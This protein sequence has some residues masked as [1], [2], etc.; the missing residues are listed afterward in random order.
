[1]ATIPQALPTMQNMQG[2]SPG[3]SVVMPQA[4]GVPSAQMQSL[5]GIETPLPSPAVRSPESTILSLDAIPPLEPLKPPNF[6]MKLVGILAAANGNFGP[7]FEIMNME[8]KTKLYQG[9]SAITPQVNR[10]ILSGR[11]EEA[12]NLWNAHITRTSS[13][14]PEIGQLMQPM[15]DRV[16]N[17]MKTA[18][19]VDALIAV[20]KHN[21]D[22]GV[23]ATDPG[24]LQNA[25]S[26]VSV[27]KKL[28]NVPDEK[29]LQQ[30]LQ[31]SV[32]K[33]YHPDP[34]SRSIISTTPMG[35]VQQIPIRSRF[36]P[37]MIKGWV[38][39]T[40][41]GSTGFTVPEIANIANGE[42]VIRG[43]EN[44][45]PS[46]QAAMVQA[47][48]ILQGVDAQRELV[49]QTPVRPEANEADRLA[50]KRQG[51]PDDLIN[52][53]MAT[54]M[55]NIPPQV[56]GLV[57]G[58]T[59]GA[60]PPVEYAE[61]G[62]KVRLDEQSQQAQTALTAQL[63][64]P[65]A[66]APN[67]ANIAIVNKEK[68]GD[69]WT[70]ESREMSYNQAKTS[71]GKWG[72]IDREIYTKKVIPLRDI[73]S[74]LKV[75]PDLF[76]EAGNPE[77]FLERLASGALRSVTFAIGTSDPRQ[78][79]LEAYALLY[80]RALEALAGTAS[81]PSTQMKTM[82]A[83][84]VKGFGSETAA[85]AATKVLADRT[86]AAIDR[87]MNESSKSVTR[88]VEK[89]AKT[90]GLT[91]AGTPI[92]SSVARTTPG[93][94]PQAPPTQPQYSAVIDVISG[95]SNIKDTMSKSTMWPHTMIDPRSGSVSALD[96]AKV[97]ASE[98]VADAKARGLKDVDRFLVRDAD[99]VD[100]VVERLT[101]IE[102]LLTN[103]KA[104]PAQPAPSILPPGVVRHK[105]R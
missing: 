53:I 45:T 85:I 28:R 18:Q 37:D 26:T 39:D 72:P 73:L 22:T 11:H 102:K 81:I 97:L 69:L 38:G 35:N 103:T 54:R 77:G 100:V 34:A 25:A 63:D 90:S 56:Q 17:S 59:Q 7:M 3:Q 29:V 40:L 95:L 87:A 96:I 30:V 19:T 105:G 46:R 67:L 13:V 64:V 32:L 58:Q 93:E 74:D 49:K 50:L 15:T 57:T 88:T 82:K 68:G 27:L 44:V 104:A 4:T 2:T 83:V 84:T 71:G 99:S 79:R 33:S 76:T 61:A 6:G 21:I 5:P 65:I 24:S 91:A 23:Y 51:L 42:A 43:S 94:T 92:P 36:T 12:I 62:R 98:R 10:M 20:G 47:I 101:G 52:L 31:T 48:T 9:L 89:N 75:L 86:E 14:A 78:A 70:T 41:S 66:A 80:D 1:M 16:Y 8:R 55:G 60:T